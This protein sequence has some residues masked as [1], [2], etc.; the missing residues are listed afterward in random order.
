MLKH[1][2]KKTPSF[3]YWGFH[4]LNKWIQIK[5]EGKS[6]VTYFED[7]EIQKIA[8]YGLGAIGKR[9]IEEFNRENIEV[10]YGIDKNAAIIQIE[11]LEIKTLEENLPAVDSVI[12]TPMSF[13]EIEKD[14][15]RKM[16]A[17]VNVI[18]IEDVIE[19]CWCQLKCK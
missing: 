14:I 6:L 17:D 12:V 10:L 9:L 15:Y 19:Y 1:Y 13:Y 18:F 7:N 8:V 4:I 16:G 11:G 5:N 2:K 3:F